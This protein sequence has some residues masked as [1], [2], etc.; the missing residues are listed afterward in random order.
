MTLTLASKGL[1][2]LKS[3]VNKA[4]SNRSELSN[5]HISLLLIYGK[6]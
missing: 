2:F 1:A 5:M 3:I 6:W 4:V